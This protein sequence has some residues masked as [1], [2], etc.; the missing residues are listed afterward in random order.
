VLRIIPEHYRNGDNV[1]DRGRLLV[2]DEYLLP[3]E[4]LKNDPLFKIMRI[5]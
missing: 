2:D 3:D 4:I 5:D 1:S